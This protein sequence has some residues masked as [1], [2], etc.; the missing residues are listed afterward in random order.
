MKES[1]DVKFCGIDDRCW[2]RETKLDGQRVV[3]QKSVLLIE[4][5]MFWSGYR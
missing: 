4:C 1:F 2:A 3:S 5:E